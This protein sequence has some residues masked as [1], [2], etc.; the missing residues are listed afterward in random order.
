MEYETIQNIVGRLNYLN[1]GFTQSS[2]KSEWK[3]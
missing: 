2:Y 1:N 3:C